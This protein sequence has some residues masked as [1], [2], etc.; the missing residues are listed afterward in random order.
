MWGLGETIYDVGLEGENGGF[1]VIGLDVGL[2]K[3]WESRNGLVRVINGCIGL[4]GGLFVGELWPVGED[5]K[6]V[7][8]G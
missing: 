8:L 4:S 7:G 3:G 6:L 1:R 5:W 2:A